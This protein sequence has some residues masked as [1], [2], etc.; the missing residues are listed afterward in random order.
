MTGVMKEE[1]ISTSP[2]LYSLA[3]MVVFVSGL[4][5]LSLEWEEWSAS[6]SSAEEVRY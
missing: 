5:R 4:D 2:C 3:G 6:C 1:I